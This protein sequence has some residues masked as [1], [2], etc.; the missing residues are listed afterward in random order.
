M[1]A[2]TKSEAYLAI[3]LRFN[4]RFDFQSFQINIPREI[5]AKF[6][7]MYCPTK[8]GVNQV[9]QVASGKIKTGKKVVTM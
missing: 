1:G 9:C 5:S 6:L 8:V 2:K 3:E 7:M 4:E